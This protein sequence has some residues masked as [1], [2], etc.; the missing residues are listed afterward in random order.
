MNRFAALADIEPDDIAGARAFYEAFA[1]ITADEAES[2]LMRQTDTT[3][4]IAEMK[5][6]RVIDRADDAAARADRRLGLRPP[7]GE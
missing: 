7:Q 2:L 4:L 5:S 3:A 6:W 1:P